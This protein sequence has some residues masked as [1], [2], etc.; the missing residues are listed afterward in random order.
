MNNM[1]YDKAFFDEPIDR[2]GTACVK[3]DGLEE[4]T[5]RE[6]N[7]MWVADMDFRGVPE[8]T[9]ALVRRAAH[10]VYGY[11]SPTESATKAML[12]F[13]QRRHNVTLTAEEQTMLPCVISGLRAAVLTLTQ[14]GDCIIVQPPVYGPFYMSVKDNKR[15]TAECPLKRDENG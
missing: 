12:D 13:M 8:I 14:P 11:T 2:R 3:W 1:K 10:P 15:V 6:M 7:P 5:G 9:E 4:R